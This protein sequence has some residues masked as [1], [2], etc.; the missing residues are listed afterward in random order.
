MS[1]R[2][3]IRP[4]SPL[5]HESESAVTRRKNS[6]ASQR[7]GPRWRFRRCPSA[8]DKGGRPPGRISARLTQLPARRS[9][10]SESRMFE[11]AA[12]RRAN[13]SCGLSF[14]PRASAAAVYAAL[15]RRSGPSDCF[16]TRPV[17]VRDSAL[18]AR[19][20]GVYRYTFL[21]SCERDTSLPL[22]L[23]G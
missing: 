10:A 3:R 11:S 5:A 20:L 18:S 6:A 9:R 19:R 1:C 16:R 13:S 7:G 21:V 4:S 14:F 12:R 22:I 17:A 2:A 8:R 23:R 15:C